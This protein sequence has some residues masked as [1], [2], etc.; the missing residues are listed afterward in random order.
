MTALNNLKFSKLNLASMIQYPIEKISTF[1]IDVPNI[2]S[3]L[4]VLNPVNSDEIYNTSLNGLP[5]VKIFEQNVINSE[6][7]LKIAKACFSYSI[8]IWLIRFVIQKMIKK[9]SGT[10]AILF[11]KQIF[12]SIITG[13]NKSR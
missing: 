4:I 2:D 8:N 5:D 12:C 3:S 7:N 9:Y 1:D 13:V 11:H 6:Y 10:L